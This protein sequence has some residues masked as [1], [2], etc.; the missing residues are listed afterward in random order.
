MCIKKTKYLIENRLADVIALLQVLAF[1]KHYARSANGLEIELQG[2]PESATSWEKVAKE[3]PEFFRVKN[4]KDDSEEIETPKISLISRHVGLSNQTNRSEPLS[5]DLAKKYFETAIELHEIQK[6]RSN[7]WLIW[8]PSLIAIISIVGN[9]FT[10]CENSKV[11]AR[12]RRYEVELKPKQES[13]ASFM[14]NINRSYYH[15]RTHNILEYAKA[16]EECESS[17]FVF[18]PFLSNSDRLHLWNEYNLFSGLCLNMIATDTSKIKNDEVFTSFS[19]TKNHFRN[20]LY[21]LLFDT[22]KAH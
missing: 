18:E 6:E 10:Q 4:G 13:Y 20:H 16:Q 7:R 15:A 8:L 5:A 14:S 2:K 1:D 21:A 11:Q 9:L 17:F 22:I 12:I 19:N 3:H